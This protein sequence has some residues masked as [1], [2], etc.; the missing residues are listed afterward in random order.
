MKAVIPVAGVGSKLRPHTHTQPK[1]LVAVAGKPILAH[2]IDFLHEGGIVEFVLIVGHLANHVEAFV[3][4][5][6]RHA[7]I[8]FNFVV[9]DQRRGS[10]HAIHAAAPLLKEAEA[11]VIALGDTIVHTD[12]NAFLKYP[13]TAIGVQK[14]DDPRL[15]GIA[16]ANENGEILQLIEKPKIPKS[17]LGLVGLYKISNTAGLLTAITEVIEGEILTNDEYHLTDALEILRKKG[18]PM[19]AFRVMHWY[20][21]GQ[22]SSLLEANTNLLAHKANTAPP[23]GAFPGCIIIPP[24]QID[25][26]CELTNSI[27]GPAVVIGQGTKI[28][29]CLVKRSIIGSYSLLSNLLLENSI[30]GN[31][32][33]LTGTLQSLNVGDDTD[34]SFG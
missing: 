14:V 3:K 16:E 11:L 7:N 34:I 28:D 26:N 25:K 23:E 12:L 20:D 8:Q 13:H 24:V 18:E 4:H 33:I 2:I 15:F 32:N 1:A 30:T 19:R 21:C 27:I 22:K 6:Y 31:D 10:A 29:S 17:N 9:Q 5:Y